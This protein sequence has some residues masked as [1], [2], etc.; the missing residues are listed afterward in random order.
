MSV[1]EGGTC[2]GCGTFAAI[3]LTPH[4]DGAVWL[5]SLCA[6]H[7]AVHEHPIDGSGVAECECDPFEIYPASTP[8]GAALRRSV[9]H[10]EE[11]HTLGCTDRCVSAARPLS[12][13]AAIQ[14]QRR[15]PRGAR[16]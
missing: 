12:R 3:I 11:D 6:H 9:E 2:P 5:C 14:T 16:V 13:A 1:G 10:S 8:E 7:V 4:G 15:R